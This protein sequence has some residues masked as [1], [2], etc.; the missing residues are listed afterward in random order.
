MRAGE[1]G[2][3][4]AIHR[5]HAPPLRWRSWGDDAVVY[6]EASGSTHL[7][8]PVGATLLRTLERGPHSTDALQAAVAEALGVAAD[9]VARRVALLLREFERLGLSGRLR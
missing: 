1:R 2:I 9:A 4:D 8:D 7:L 3:G 5:L 6:H